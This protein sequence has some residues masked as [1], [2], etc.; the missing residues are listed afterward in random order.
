MNAETRRQLGNRRV[1]TDYRERKN[2]FWL[3]LP[4]IVSKLLE[5]CHRDALV[6]PNMYI[7]TERVNDFETSWFRV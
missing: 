3:G 1:A 6:I 2:M 7:H 4:A 5:M